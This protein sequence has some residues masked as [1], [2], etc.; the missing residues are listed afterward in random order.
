L[1][2]GGRTETYNQENTFDYYGPDGGT[3]LAGVSGTTVSGGAT[4]WRAGLVFQP[5]EFSS[6]FVSYATGFNPVPLLDANAAPLKPEMGRQIE[7][8]HT[9][10][11]GG[12]MLELNTT[13]FNLVK[14]N[15]VN[16]VGAG[17]Y[18]QAG[19]LNTQGFE[20]EL[21]IWP[22]GMAELSAGYTYIDARWA[23]YLVYIPPAGPGLGVQADYMGNRPS[24]VPWHSATARLTL[25]PGF[26]LTIGMGGRYN[27]ESYADDANFIPLAGYALADCLVALKA[28]GVEYRVN[29]DNVFDKRDAIIG[30]QGVR[31]QL[32]PVAPRTVKATMTV[33]F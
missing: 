18:D 9:L 11:I 30:T 14:N 26:G 20:A 4:T 32:Y 10:D 29:V 31:N 21:Q 2:A 27:G 13:Y 22:G 7:A 6:W 16:S 1:L 5:A 25:R 28:G 8:G 24:L 33:D 23:D 15:A 17:L 12:D 19:E 3:T